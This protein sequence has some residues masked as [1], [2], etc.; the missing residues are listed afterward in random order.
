MTS[1]TDY[2]TVQHR[3]CDDSY[4]AAESAVSDNN[5]EEAG[6][7]W[8]TFCDDLETHLG[9]EEETL[10]PAFEE[11]D[12]HTGG[13]TSVMRMEH[14]QM[15]ALA[16]QMTEAL[17]QKN[18]DSYLGLSETLMVLMQQH[19]MKEEQIL[20]PMTQQMLPDP[21]TMVESMKDL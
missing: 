20:Y 21:A 11:A 10:F 6:K 13:P 2:M 14:E 9:N 19:N 15:R 4:A 3:V 12:G 8:Q 18:A 1:I 17:G 16:A 7:Q 5:W